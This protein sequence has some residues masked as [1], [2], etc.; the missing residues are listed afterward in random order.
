MLWELRPTCVTNFCNEVHQA[1]N[2]LSGG[3]WPGKEVV[4]GWR[5]RINAKIE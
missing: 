4:G 2:E 1:G 5:K 3:L